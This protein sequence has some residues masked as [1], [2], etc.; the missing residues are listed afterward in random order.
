MIKKDI[1]DHMIKMILESNPFSFVRYGDGEWACILRNNDI[2][3]KLLKTWGSS[4]E[5]VSFEL[6]SIVSSNVFK[7]KNYFLGIQNLAY[8]IFGEQIDD[9]IKDKNVCD[10]DILHRRSASDGIYSLFESFVDRD[11]ILVGPKY[12]SDI[13]TFKFKHIETSELSVWLDID[14]IKTDLMVCIDDSTNPIV[15]YSCSLA[16]KVI[17]NDLYKLMGNSITQI[18]MGSLLDPYVGVYS[19]TYHKI[20]L[21]RLG[22]DESNIKLSK[23]KPNI[24]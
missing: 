6:E 12:L 19:R 20:V 2:Y 1:Y 8:T 24:K 22:Y 11:V 7:N 10:S 3:S 5:T 13:S 14:Q 18:D 21:N 17:I 4:I 23:H 9:I 15:L 16:A